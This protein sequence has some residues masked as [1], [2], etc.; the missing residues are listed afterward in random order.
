MYPPTH[1]NHAKCIPQAR[2]LHVVHAHSKRSLR[3]LPRKRKRSLCSL[4]RNRKRSPCSLSRKRKRALRF[5]PRIVRLCALGSSAPRLGSARL[6]RGRPFPARSVC[7]QDRLTLAPGGQQNQPGRSQAT[8]LGL[9][10]L[11]GPLLLLWC[12]RRRRPSARKRAL[13]QPVRDNPL[14]GV[15]SN[16]FPKRLG[17]PAFVAAR[18]IVRNRSGQLLCCQQSWRDQQRVA[19]FGQFT[20]LPLS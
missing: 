7:P 13:R 9:S 12:V 1:P 17:P 8:A 6:P 3:S 11:C 15:F 18:R 14:A 19:N 10:R 2:I 5:L 20:P 16:S 4:S